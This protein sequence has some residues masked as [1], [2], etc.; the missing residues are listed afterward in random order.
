MESAAA[1]VQA[2]RRAA[3]HCAARCSRT[4]PTRTRRS[5]RTAGGFRGC[6]CLHRGAI[7]LLFN[8]CIFWL[9]I[10]DFLKPKSVL[11]WVHL[12]VSIHYWSFAPNSL[13][14]CL[15]FAILYIQSLW[16]RSTCYGCS[17]TSST[18]HQRAPAADDAGLRSHA[19]WVLLLLML[20]I[21]CIPKIIFQNSNWIFR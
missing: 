5:W 21:L 7:F 9:T 2:R 18:N 20:Q 10:Y 19:A 16:K 4:P 13:V 8:G 6:C 11:K 14:S 17:C 3:A 1:T 15:I 12:P